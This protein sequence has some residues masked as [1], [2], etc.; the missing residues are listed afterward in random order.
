VIIW[1]LAAAGSLQALVDSNASDTTHRLVYFF[2]LVSF[3][4]TSQVVSNIVHV[5]V[6]GTIASWYFLYPAHMPPNP[7]VGAFKR[8]SWT[9][10]G[11]IAFGSFIIAV[12]RAIRA[13]VRQGRGSK[14]ACAQ[15][16]AECLIG[17]L[18]NLVTYFNVYAFTQVAIYGKPYC[19]AAS[20]TWNLFKRVGIDA[21]INDDIIGGVL[22]FA[23]FIGACMVGAIAAV[24]AKFAFSID[25]WGYWVAIGFIVGYAMVMIAMEVVASSVCALFV[26]FSEDPAALQQSKPEVYGKFYTALTGHRYASQLRLTPSSQV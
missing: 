5:T 4:W 8:A 19:E 12:I 18:D 21:I 3:Y 7:T 14:N 6:A 20:D 16:I 24:M 22:A 9:S 13:I 10:F 23:S 26:C 11:S 15:C 1:A 25:Y 2:F 17:C